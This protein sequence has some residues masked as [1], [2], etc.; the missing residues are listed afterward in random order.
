MAGLGQPGL[1]QLIAPLPAPLHA[2]PTGPCNHRDVAGTCGCRQFWDKCSAEIHQHSKQH[3]SSS[4]RSTYCVCGH[5]ACFHEYSNEQAQVQA[6][7]V[8][9]QAQPRLSS[10][11]DGLCRA[12]GLACDHHKSP[13]LRRDQLLAIGSQSPTRLKISNNSGEQRL[14][15]NGASQANGSGIDELA[16]MASSMSSTTG[17]PRIPSMCLLSHDRY[18][19]A[20]KVNRNEADQSRATIA[21]LGLSMLNVDATQNINDGQHSVVST[22]PDEVDLHGGQLEGAHGALQAVLEYNQGLHLDI[23]GDTIPNTYNPEEYIQSATEVATPSITNTP[24][25][26]MADKAVDEGKKFME[27]L[28]QLASNADQRDVTNARPNTDA[29]GS[30]S[31]LLMPNSPHTPEDQMKNAIRSASPQTLQKLFSYLT[32]LH[33]LLKSMP[34]V[35]KSMREHDDR[36]AVLEQNN[37]FNFVHPDDLHQQ[38]DAYDGR[39]F[40]LENRMDD[41][42]AL[43]LTIDA[44]QSS[45]SRRRIAAVNESFGSTNS[46]QSSTSSALIL[47][48]MDRKDVATEIGGIKERLDALEAVALP[49]S[50]NPWD[51]EIVLLPW[52]RDLRGIWFS[53]DEPMHDPSKTTTQESEE[54][55]QARSSTLGQSRTSLVPLR[56]SDS[57][58]H[59]SLGRS[60]RSSHP[61]SDTESG[62]SSQ[63]ISEWVSGSSSELLS[64]KACGGNNLVYKR[65]KSR[66]L[67]ADVKFTSANATD[68][69][70]T[71]SHAFKDLLE[72]FKY[73]DDDESP[74]I[75][76]YPGLRA[77]FIPLRK[78]IK[79]SRLRFLTPAEM[80]SS[81]LWTA[82]FLASGVLMRV[83]GGKKRLYV[84]QREAYIQPMDQTGDIWTWHEMRLLPRWQPDSDSQMEGNDEHCQPQVH[85]ADAREACWAFF[86]AYDA[87]PASVTSSFA[88]VHS[89][90]L[91]MRPA[92]RDWR[93]SMT[94]TS[95]L[96]NRQPPQPISPLS[97]FHNRP[98]RHRTVSASI[99]EPATSSSKRR[100]NSSPVKQ[101]SA[102]QSQSRAP[103]QIMSRLK[104]R[105]VTNS[106][107][108]RPQVETREAQ[109]TIWA[110]T[111]RRSREPPSPFYSSD[112]SRPSQRSAALAG[113]STPFAY[114]TPHSGAFVSALGFGR[115]DTE[116]DTDI[117]QDDDGEQSWRGL[118]TGEDDSD[119]SS[120]DAEAGA[121]VQLVDYS[122]EDSALGSDE[123]DIEDNN[124]NEDVGVD[125]DADE[126]IFDP[127][128]AV[129]EDDED[130]DGDDDVYDTLLGVLR[131]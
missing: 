129:E 121:Q 66:G 53:P 48:A 113:K 112:L 72:R 110:N 21:G 26:A 59:P 43:H 100:L 115:G 96:K 17:L 95:I 8:Q 44:D 31:K 7:Q 6:Q 116:A 36:L 65:L 114:A 55:T 40:H 20:N 123:D 109:A 11:C 93:R 104:R 23:G 111:P 126:D 38:L 106:S 4:E 12:Q 127:Q 33:N 2:L 119:S 62:W 15:S 88:S 27:G 122:D 91:S 28:M 87:P 83:S 77:S 82:Q 30:T 101:T 71:I 22:V 35:A 16:R 74:M 37:S 64:P 60:P 9:T 18:P 25:L 34:D 105:R 85:E 50:L 131:S 97:E 78:V 90:Q 14:I 61:F 108:P 86:E 1:A 102:P 57:S 67:I 46:L 52:G 24:D 10:R 107:S 68:I 103:S 39:L 47:A 73:N 92:E 45:S 49:T 76:S 120:D 3:P 63:E 51:V 94:P 69:Q 42:E 125:V 130:E 5:H 29:S 84:T 75:N 89:V 13:N 118:T 128:Q 117:Y 81:A 99:V 98:V 41:H 54:W 56:D 32:P 19:A 70:R 80:A 58:P 79:D 124:A